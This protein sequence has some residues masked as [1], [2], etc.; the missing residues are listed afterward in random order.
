MTPL[1]GP[2]STPQADRNE[3]ALA[4]AAGVAELAAAAEIEAA[5]GEGLLATCVRHEIALGHRL[6][7]QYAAAGNAALDV[8][9]AGPADDVA[10]PRADRVAARLGG[11]TAHVM[12]NVR[13][14]LLALA[15]APAAAAEQWVPVHFVGEKLCSPEE[16]ARR[17]AVAKAARAAAQGLPADNG[18]ARILTAAERDCLGHA[19]AAA[20]A[21]AAEGGVATLARAAG[22]WGRC[23]TFLRHEFAAAHRLVM[24]LGGRA[25]DLLGTAVGQDDGIAALRLG[26]AAA[27]LMARG[28]QALATLP[29]LGPGPGGGPGRVAGYYWIGEKDMFAR[30]GAPANAEAG[31]SAASASST[32]LVDSPAKAGAQGRRSVTCPWAPAFAGESRQE[33]ER[34]LRRRGRLRNGNP[35][36]DY[37]SA[38]RCG[39]RTRADCACRQP[40]MANGRCRFHGGKSTGPRTASGLANSRAARRTHGGYAAEIIDLRKAAIAHA[41]RMQALR[42]LLAGRRQR[43]DSTP[44]LIIPLPTAGSRWTWGSSALLAR[45]LAPRPSGRSPA[46]SARKASR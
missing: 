27:R 5:E 44:A 41:R 6:A 4:A 19:E 32:L 31:A 22:E 13:L 45:G 35:S 37:M 14:A 40:A 3:A 23:K 18:P 15:G 2:D 16:A 30:E 17:L 12:G 43:D 34:S 24:R 26:S 42:C 28:R 9:R 39:A 10:V 38:P 36:G 25:G 21:L 7:M 8:A 11:A 46:P 29:R 1:D 33:G 20:D